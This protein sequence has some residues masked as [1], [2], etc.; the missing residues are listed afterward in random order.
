M[1]VKR[2]ARN[3]HNTISKNCGYTP[4]MYDKFYKKIEN[5]V[6][7][8]GVL[9]LGGDT[10]K[11]TGGFVFEMTEYYIPGTDLKLRLFSN[12]GKN[13]TCGG[14]GMGFL[15]DRETEETLFQVML[16]TEPYDEY[17]LFNGHSVFWIT[18]DLNLF[19]AQLLDVIEQTLEQ[20]K[21]LKNYYNQSKQIKVDPK[22][23]AKLAE[24]KERL[25]SKPRLRGVSGVVIADK[26]ANMMRSGKIEGDITPAKGKQLRE[27]IMKKMNSKGRE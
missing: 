9:K 7:E 15:D 16:G 27:Q 2:I 4:A 26:I 13:A 18:D 23:R 14:C 22:L 1:I 19:A 20:K 10:F 11:T 17:N 12:Q 3:I 21:P 8:N 25:K 6:E 5:A 24:A